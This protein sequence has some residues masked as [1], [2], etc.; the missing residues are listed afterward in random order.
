MLLSPKCL[1]KILAFSFCILFSSVI[2]KAAI[3]Q[4]YE[5]INYTSYRT[6]DKGKLIEEDEIL[7]QIND[8]LGEKYNKF[9]IPYS[10]KNKLKSLDAQIEDLSGNVIR[11]LKKSEIKNVSAIS[12]IA[13]Y[14]D[15]YVAKFSLKYNKYPYRIRINYR[16][17]YNEFLDIA[18]WYP[19]E[20]PDIPTRNAKLVVKIPESYS[21]HYKQN[22]TDDPEI[23]A[24]EGMKIYTWET[25]YLNTVEE[26]LYSPPM[27][28]FIPSVIVIPEEFVYG[29]PGSFTDWE[30]FGLWTY[31][32]INGL[33]ELP[34]EEKGR[35]NSLLKDLKTDREKVRA[36]YHY[37]QD[38][39]RYINVSIDIGGLKPYPAEY[40]SYN[41]YGDC[42]ALTNYMK[43][44]L[45][46]AGIESYYSKIF[47]D[48]QIPPFD[49]AFP[50]Q[51]S[52]HA[53]L[54]VPLEKDTLW[55]E[56]TSTTTPFGY[57]ST[58]IQN[59]YALKVDSNASR[60]V[61]TPA[62]DDNE[63]Q[64]IRFIEI[65][66]EID[67][68]ARVEFN[69]VA[70]GNLFEDLQFFNSYANQHYKD[71]VIKK[72]FRFSD[73]EMTNWTLDQMNRDSSFVNL[74]ASLL[75]KDHAKIYNKD[76]I[77]KVLQ[78]NIP[79]F[80]HSSKR[81]LPVQIDYPIAQKDELVYHW[82]ESWEPAVIPKPKSLKITYGEYT[83]DV[84]IGKDTIKVERYFKLNPGYYPIDEY[85][86]FYEFIESVNQL[87]R[88]NAFIFK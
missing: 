75:L 11:K 52:N 53:I 26:E 38:N 45:K 35:V 4:N 64:S 88:D 18:K 78:A 85:K 40:V 17:E 36:L 1:L 56:C 23:K 30:S 39:T 83:F 24:E 8:R 42:K 5:V 51:F 80:E 43:S 54:N 15:E 3:A 22:N 79:D 41:K 84:E 46:E 61:K 86:L 55:L 66:F 50:M 47:A 31:N 77:V 7:V 34:Y 44:L 71:Q 37:L 58:S 10:S 48:E 49:S 13:F 27:N 19:V 25:S 65:D 63:I 62:M 9:E 59:R 82:P 2:Q 76:I 60:L 74:N 81:S 70:R 73:Y 28:N 33:D 68:N 57:I 69:I 29:I 12:N 20:S 16:T 87:E 6:V 72:M 21:I 14:E 32:L 67:G